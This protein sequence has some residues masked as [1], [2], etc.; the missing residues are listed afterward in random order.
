[1]LYLYNDIYDF[2]LYVAKCYDLTKMRL[3]ASRKVC[4][5][6]LATFSLQKQEVIIILEIAS[7][8]NKYINIQ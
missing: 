2:W 7:K 6:A 8:L 5:W 4:V 1:M 3:Y